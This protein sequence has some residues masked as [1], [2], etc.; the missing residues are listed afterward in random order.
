MCHSYSLHM[1]IYLHISLDTIHHL[2][3][4]LIM[5]LS[6]NRS[7][8]PEEA[9]NQVIWTR[10]ISYDRFREVSLRSC[11]T[12]H[13]SI[14]NTQTPSPNSRLFWCQDA[15]E[16][17][18]GSKEPQEQQHTRSTVDPCQVSWWPG[19][20]MQIET[21]YTC[22]CV[23][24]SNIDPIQQWHSGAPTEAIYPRKVITWKWATFEIRNTPLLKLSNHRVTLKASA[25]Q[26]MF[27]NTLKARLT[28]DQ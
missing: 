3:C 28:V 1:I 15:N 20:A 22:F 25:D 10:D 5:L 6:F 7:I 24:I 27:R 26:S 19:E 8:Q 17:G 9:T 11:A 23:W 18:L 13:D 14:I 2:F 12:E 16:R 4:Q 21:R